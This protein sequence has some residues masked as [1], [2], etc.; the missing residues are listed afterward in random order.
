MSTMTKVKQLRNLEGE[1]VSHMT[2]ALEAMAQNDKLGELVAKGNI[3][4]VRRDIAEI[5]GD[6]A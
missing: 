5:E 1:R 2:A 6:R 3:E 4:I